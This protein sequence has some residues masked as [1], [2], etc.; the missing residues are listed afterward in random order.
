MHALKRRLARTRV[1]PPRV[2]VVTD[3]AGLGVYSVHRTKKAARLAAYFYAARVV[4][5]DLV[6]SQK[7]R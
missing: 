7:V 6:E 2:W 5:Y 1:G 3:G 4:R